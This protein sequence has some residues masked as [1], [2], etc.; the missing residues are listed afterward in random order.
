MWSRE[1]PFKVDIA[2]VIE[3]MDRRCTA[4]WTPPSVNFCK[5]HMMPSC[6]DAVV[7][8]IFED[9]LM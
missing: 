7:I 5:T 6:A 1:I 2:G 4:A 9:G 8:S 3:I